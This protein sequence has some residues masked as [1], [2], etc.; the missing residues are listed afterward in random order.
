ME[1]TSKLLTLNFQ[2]NSSVANLSQ[3]E[4]RAHTEMILVCGAHG[5]DEIGHL[6]F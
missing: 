3:V 2:F 4:I 1:S 5:F 6:V